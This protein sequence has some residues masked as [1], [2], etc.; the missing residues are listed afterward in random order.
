MTWL[1]LI[2]NAWP[3][4]WPTLLLRENAALRAKIAR[5]ETRIEL[6]QLEAE[7]VA[8]VNESYRRWLLSSTAVAKH[9][10]DALGVKELDQPKRPPQETL[11]EPKPFVFSEPAVNGN[12][13][14]TLDFDPDRDLPP[15]MRIPK[16]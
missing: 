5:L 8:Q 6:L 9:V 10:G 15:E 2:L 13:R 14:R 3:W 11:Q 16:R 12:G 4:S 1:R 7:G